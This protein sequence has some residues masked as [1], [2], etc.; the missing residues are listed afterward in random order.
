[1][2][3]ILIATFL[4]IVVQWCVPVTGSCRHA[5]IS[6]RKCRRS[7]G[8]PRFGLAPA[9]S[10]LNDYQPA[11]SDVPE[12]D[13]PMNA[14]PESLSNPFSDEAHR[15]C[16]EHLRMSEQQCG[17]I[18]LFVEEIISWNERV[19]L[20]SRR[21]CTPDSIFSRH[22]VPSLVGGRVLEE[23]LLKNHQ[24]NDGVLRLIDVGTGGGF[25]GIPLAILYPQIQFVLADS[26][27]KKIT[28]VTTMANDLKLSNVATY[29]GRV[30]DFFSS[31]QVAGHAASRKKFDIVTG[32]SVTS[33]PRFCALV[34]DLIEP[35][36][37]HV[38]Y[39]TGGE[40]DPSIEQ[41]SI[42]NIA[43]EEYLPAFWKDNC[44]KRVLVFPYAA[45]RAI[46]ALI[47][48][49][50]QRNISS[51]VSKLA[52]RPARPVEPGRNINQ[53]R[54]KG[55]WRRKNDSDQPKQRGYENFQRYASAPSE[56]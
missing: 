15:F 43:I 22:I 10:P 25:P 6:V 49:Q 53:R 2:S 21:T 5:W 41:L 55:A 13:L 32:R 42:R 33:L 45:V 34:K 51:S 14:F 7:C 3:Y 52:R 26:I 54:P 37:G 50:E 1:M 47:P 27:G 46:A 12:D 4:W 56:D 48:K 18:Q 17:L 9:E 16:I 35:D 23:A 11:V 39:L 28:A 24:G 31:T 29:N 8:S 36:H 44:D 30:E 38:L 19:N 40:I 20:V